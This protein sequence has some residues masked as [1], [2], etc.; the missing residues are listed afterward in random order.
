MV[1]FFMGSA[2]WVTVILLRNYLVDH[3][4]FHVGCPVVGGLSNNSYPMCDSNF[5]FMW[6]RDVM[7]SKPS[8]NGQNRRNPAKRRQK[9]S[10]SYWG[11]SL[12]L[13]Y[14]K[15]LLAISPWLK[16]WGFINFNIY[17]LPGCLMFLWRLGHNKQQLLAS[18]WGNREIWAPNSTSPLESSLSVAAGVDQDGPETVILP[19][20]WGKDE[21]GGEWG[22]GWVGWIS[23][24]IWLVV[25]TIFY[26]PIYWVSNH[27]NWLIFF[28]GV[29]TTNQS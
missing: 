24:F 16:L 23:N 28:R 7:S 3:L 29:Q 21:D 10:C 17:L 19:S 22:W 27:P 13:F 20:R 9:I 12:S 6:A 26:F 15:L 8:G 11:W 2:I 18:R 1:F 14:P 25:W 5:T 4:I